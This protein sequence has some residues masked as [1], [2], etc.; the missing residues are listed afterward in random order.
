MY[1]ITELNKSGLCYR[2]KNSIQGCDAEAL[3]AL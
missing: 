1:L 2:L 3:Y